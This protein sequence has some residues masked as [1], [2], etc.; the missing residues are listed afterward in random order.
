MCIV[1]YNQD[2]VKKCIRREFYYLIV[3]SGPK[4]GKA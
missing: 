4:N 2:N 1:Q 3:S